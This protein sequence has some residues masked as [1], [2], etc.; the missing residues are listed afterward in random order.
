M[1][2]FLD[3]KGIILCQGCGEDN[4]HAFGFKYFHRE[5]DAKKGIMVSANKGVIVINDSMKGCPSSR[6]GGIIV[7]FYCEHCEYITEIVIEQHKGNE[8]FNIR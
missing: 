1:N 6:R 3:E 7:M 8:F 4:L 2:D 5:E